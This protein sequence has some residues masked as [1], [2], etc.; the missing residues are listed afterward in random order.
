MWLARLD[1]QGSVIIRNTD[2]CD[3]RCPVNTIN[4]APNNSKSM[5]ISK[6]TGYAVHALAYMVFRNSGT[7]VQISEISKFQ[8]V[9]RTYLA[10]IFQQL[11]AADLVSGQR[12]V[13]GGYVLVRQP[14]SVTLFDIV[15]AI[16]GPVE[17]DHCCLGILGCPVKPRCVVLEVFSHVNKNLMENLKSI[18]LRDITS[19]MNEFN[20]PYISSHHEA[21]E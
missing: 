2:G 21:G 5:N 19:K 4:E 7:P 17:K 6:S 1:F 14:E 16:E 12:G 10:K 15:E 13:S 11:A 3:L 18:T 20:A 9:S 8:N